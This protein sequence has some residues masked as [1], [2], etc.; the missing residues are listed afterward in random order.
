MMAGKSFSSNFD[1]VTLKSKL[2]PSLF[3]IYDLGGGI[4]LGLILLGQPQRSHSGDLQDPQNLLNQGLLIDVR[5]SQI[6]ECFLGEMTPAAI[7]SLVLI[8][9]DEP[10]RPKKGR[11][12]LLRKKSTMLPDGCQVFDMCGLIPGETI[13]SSRSGGSRDDRLTKCSPARIFI[14]CCAGTGI[15]FRVELK[16]VISPAGVNY[17]HLVLRKRKTTILFSLGTERKQRWRWLTASSSVVL[18]V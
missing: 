6:P 18:H 2:Q 8:H 1:D 16:N 3:D 14:P 4:P 7:H 12:Q 10:S 13:P 5:S 17:P 11:L 9:I 15:Y